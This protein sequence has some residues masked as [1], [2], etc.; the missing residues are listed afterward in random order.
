MGG[1]RSA[2]VEVKDSTVSK[3]TG[4]SGQEGLCMRVCVRSQRKRQLTADESQCELGRRGKSALSDSHVPERVSDTLVMDSL[5]QNLS[6]GHQSHQLLQ[7]TPLDLFETGKALKFQAERP[8]L[9]SLGSG[10]LSTAITLLPLPEDE[11]G[12]GQMGSGLRNVVLLSDKE[13]ANISKTTLGHGAMDIS[14]QGPGIAAQH[15]FIENR[16]GVITLHPCGNQC[17]MDGLLVAK[18]V[19]LSQEIGG[20]DSGVS[21]YTSS[22]P[23]LI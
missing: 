7:S 13:Q 10:R 19:R 23:S 15:C 4:M 12:R 14:I 3:S 21:N 8:H 5:N 9:V 11:G 16:A 2:L 1:I 18:P 22:F 20:S 17:S 6:S